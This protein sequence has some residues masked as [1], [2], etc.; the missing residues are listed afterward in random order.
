MSDIVTQTKL[1]LPGSQ[2]ENFDL[3]DVNNKYF[4]YC[5][6]F[7]IFIFDRKD[8][9]LRN[10]LGDNPDKYISAISLGQSPSEELL[11]VYYYQTIVIYNL[12]TNKSSFS[13]PFN[14]VKAMKFNQNS[15]LLILIH[16]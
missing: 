8:F 7:S 11:A 4:I 3:T 10:I 5:S 14:G 6:T 15:N 2:I 1:I 9:E 16:I 12:F 13:I